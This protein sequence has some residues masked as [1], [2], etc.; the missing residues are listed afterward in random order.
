M[1]GDVDKEDSHT[2][3]G[4]GKEK[5]GNMETK[6]RFSSEVTVPQVKEGARPLLSEKCL[7]VGTESFMVPQL[8]FFLKKCPEAP[9]KMDNL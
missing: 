9:F 7:S 2:E 6:G 1:R 5:I 8:L 4:E 3:T